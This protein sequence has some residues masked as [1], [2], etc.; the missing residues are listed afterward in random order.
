MIGILAFIAVIVFIVQVYKTAKGTGRNGAL[1]AILTGIVGFGF[2]IVVPLFIGLALGIY[3]LMT[4]SSPEE[5]EIAVN[6]WATLI[7]L[8]CLVLSIVGV[9][10]IMKHVSKIPDEPVSAAVPPPPPPTFA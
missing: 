10:L 8:P 1:W 2:Q 5:M 3:Y 9:F 4:G 6:G 7:G